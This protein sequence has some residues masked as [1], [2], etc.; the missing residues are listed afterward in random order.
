VP[1]AAAAAIAACC[2]EGRFD[3]AER[4]RRAVASGNPVIPLVRDL[5]ALLPDHAAPYVHLGATSQD[6]LDTAAALVARRALGPILADLGGA[7]DR[8]AALAG[9]HRGTILAGRTLLQ[10]ALPVTFGLKCAGWLVA[11]DEARAA[12]AAVRERRLAVQLGGAA[13]TLASLGDAGVAMVGLLAEQ[14]GL[15]EPTMP[16]HTN[17]TRVAELAGALGTASGVLAKIALDVVLLAQTE[18]AEVA[19]AAGEGRGGSSTMPHKRNP[20]RA[21]LVTACARRV[22]GL[23]ATLLAAMAQEH[24]RAAGAWH[25]EW[26]PLVELLRL[27]GGAAAGARELLDGLQVD[28]ARM[29]E[30]LDRSGGLLLAERVAGRLAGA[31]GRTGAD[32][33]LARVSRA[34]A[35]QGRTLREALLDEPAVREHLSEAQ[36]DAALDPASYLGS[37]G[38]FVDRALAAHAAWDTAGR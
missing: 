15:A 29:R 23:V 37:A 7:A 20:V 34:A 22:P 10:Q 30:D 5:A 2:A 26:Q 12:L 28:A 31:L 8:C 4:G 36:L 27:T 21:V 6:V 9:E 3:A 35:A 14:L 38:Q 17:R 16:W 32:D 19:E 1:A 25:A 11:V 24:E 13:G 33:L 18:V